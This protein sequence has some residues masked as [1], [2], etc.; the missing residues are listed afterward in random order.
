MANPEAG[1]V[2]LDKVWPML[3]DIAIRDKAP[4]VEGRYVNMLVLPKVQK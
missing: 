4:N 1:V 3:E 2:V